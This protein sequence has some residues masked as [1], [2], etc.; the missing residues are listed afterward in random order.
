VRVRRP[1]MTRT[2]IEGDRSEGAPPPRRGRG[3]AAPA[4][5]PRSLSAR[6]RAARAVVAAV[7]VGLVASLLGMG[8]GAKRSSESGGLGPLGIA[9]EPPTISLAEVSQHSGELVT[10]ETTVASARVADGEAVLVPAGEDPDGGLVIAIAPPLIGPSAVDL[11]SRFAGQRV[12][13]IGRVSDLGGRLEIL[14][15]DPR[16]VQVVDATGA[17]VRPAVPAAP[18]PP[19]VAPQPV[20]PAPAA[21]PP[22]AAAPPP[23]APAP[24][25]AAPAAASAAPAPAPAAASAAPAPAPAA[26]SAAPAPAPAAAPAAPAPAP[27][28]APAAPAPAPAREATPPSPPSQDEESRRACESAR[29]A[30]QEAAAAAKAPLAELQTCLA[31]GDPPCTRESARARIAMAEVAASEERVRWLCGGR[32]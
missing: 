5:L 27:A 12:R 8:C 7:V 23:S 16:R 6:P 11:V 2:S 9:P 15:G 26:A 24:L 14:V 18:I 13:A 29:R 3:E 32:E 1:D 19:P 21:A 22:A 28:E 17:V 4:P 30:W 25:R 20:A 10:V 31:T